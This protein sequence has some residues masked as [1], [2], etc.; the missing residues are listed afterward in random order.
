MEEAV[1]MPVVPVQEA[2]GVG[3]AKHAACFMV[4][5]MAADA[6]LALCRGRGV[7]D[8]APPVCCWLLAP[9]LDADSMGLLVGVGKQAVPATPVV[10]ATVF[11]S[12]T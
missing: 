6:P 12:G 1:D 8:E 4:R 2:G 11:P 3:P 10:E 9:L 7:L 5:C